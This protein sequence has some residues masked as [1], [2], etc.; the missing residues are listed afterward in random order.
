M[1]ERASSNA[2]YE[3]SSNGADDDVSRATTTV[4]ATLGQP[5]DISEVVDASNDTVVNPSRNR[6]F[7]D[8]LA[9]RISRRT[10]LAGGLGVAAGSFFGPETADATGFGVGRFR[11]LQIGFAPVSLPQYVAE[12]AIDGETGKQPVISSDYQFDVLIP[13]GTPINPDSGVAEYAGDPSTRPSSADQEQM[14][15][16]GHDGMWYFALEY[17]P[18]KNG[19]YY[20]Y[21]RFFRGESTSGMLCINH[22]FGTNEHVLDKPTPAQS[23][24]D[25]RLSRRAVHGV[26]VVEDREGLP[27]SSGTSSPSPNSRRITVN[28]PVEFSRPSRQRSCTRRSFRTRTESEQPLTRVRSTTAATATDPLGHLPDLRRELQRATLA[29]SRS[30]NASVNHVFEDIT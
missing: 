6:D 12:S 30:L 23:L 15:G 21:S 8:V 7:E 18:R 17:D 3:P 11:N 22:E 27:R 26:S 20:R 29:P 28:T 10:V 14:I 1:D 19:D 25:V 16:L 4:R 2:S 24:E 13:W 9:A 5:A